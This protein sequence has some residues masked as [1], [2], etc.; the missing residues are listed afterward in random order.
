MRIAAI[1]VYRVHL[2]VKGNGFR[3]SGGRVTRSLDSTV[4]QTHT[5]EGISGWGESC[6]IGPHYLP[7]LAEGARAGIQV[8]APHL[9]GQDSREL[10]SI[11]HRMN[12]ELFGIPYAK[13][14]LED[15]VIDVPNIKDRLR[16]KA[17]LARLAGRQP[18]EFEHDLP[19]P[20]LREFARY[21]AQIL[22][23]SLHRRWHKCRGYTSQTTVGVQPICC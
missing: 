16:T 10:G 6:P 2:P 8:L 17:S 1:S 4:V 15:R 21:I 11:N 5:N 9:I 14:A 20:R 13:T 19:A 3:F 12:S 23:R 22:R 7:A 18:P